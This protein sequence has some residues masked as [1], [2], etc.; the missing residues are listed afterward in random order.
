MSQH[1][2]MPTMGA[3]VS[4]TLTVLPMRGHIHGTN[5]KESKG[6]NPGAKD[7]QPTKQIDT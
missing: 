3:Y 4:K 7:R 2:G 1:P 5:Q 6:I